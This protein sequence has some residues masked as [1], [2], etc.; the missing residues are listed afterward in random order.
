MAAQDVLR[1]CVPRSKWA[2]GG[3]EMIGT[4]KFFVAVNGIIRSPGTGNV[5]AYGNGTNATPMG[6]GTA[7]EIALPTGVNALVPG[8][9]LDE[10]LT[11]SVM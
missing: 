11:L 8:N 6:I 1:V 10:D 9:E 2:L 4:N 3:I 7:V 5:T